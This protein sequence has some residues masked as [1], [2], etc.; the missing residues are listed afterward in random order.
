[1]TR[2]QI[3]YPVVQTWM[4]CSMLEVWLQISEFPCLAQASSHRQGPR[5]SQASCDLDVPLLKDGTARG[6]VH[7]PTS[8][9]SGSQEL[10]GDRGY[11][12]L[13]PPSSNSSWVLSGACAE[14]CCLEFELS[15][16]PV[17]VRLLWA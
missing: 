13:A 5:Q 7:R 8:A 9:I 3:T 17:G 14:C 6:R 10:A 12:V 16:H 2:Q 4:T 11:A 1:M 15:G